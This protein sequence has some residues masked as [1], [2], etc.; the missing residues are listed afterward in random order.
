MKILL[1]NT[2]MGLVPYGDDAYDQKKKLQRNRVYQ[3][4]IKEVKPRNLE[5]LRK[6]HKLIS[7]AWD[8]L[9]EQQQTFFHDN[10]ELFRET[11]EIAAGNCERFY[12][13]KR[14]TWLERKKSIA[15]DTMKEDEF[16]DVYERVKDV[17]MTYFLNTISEEEFTAQL[18]DF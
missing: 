6:Y 5:F 1:L 7:V 14:Q 8:Y 3:V 15:F 9:N 16:S 4:D 11:V 2:D 17:L 12:D 10:R 18:M 13:I